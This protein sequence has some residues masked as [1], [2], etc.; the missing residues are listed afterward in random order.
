MPSAKPYDRSA[1]KPP[2]DLAMADELLTSE[3]EESY[4][5]ADQDNTAPIQADNLSVLGPTVHFKGELSADEDLMIQGQV[6]GS[7]RHTAR[8]LTIGSQGKVKADVHAN[9]VIVQGELR[10]D[11]FG[12]EAVIVEA[13][14]RVRGN[15]FAPRVALKEGAK[16]KGSIDMD[17]TDESAPRR[18]P[19]KRASERKKA[20]D[21][22]TISESNVNELLG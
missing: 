8:N 13:S 6:E 12:T 9:H 19:A 11:L 3:H 16:F 21:K 10:G 22:K 20:S 4:E 18:Q 2:E 14:A 7:I 1:Y 17:A 15:I 5:S